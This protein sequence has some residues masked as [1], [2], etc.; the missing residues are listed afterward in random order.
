MFRV[1]S[2]GEFNTPA[3]DYIKPVIC[4]KDNLAAA[5]RL[6]GMA[7]I[8]K[9]GFESILKDIQASS[10]VYLDPPYRP[11][12]LTANFTAYSKSVFADRQQQELAL[13]FSKLDK[14]G[15][16]V[17]LSNSDS[18]DFFFD[19][20]YHSFNI[21]RVPAKRLINS[22]AGKRGPVHEIVVTNYTV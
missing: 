21:V 13:V 19:R 12:S 1:N 11:L 6:L 16:A 15:V 20:L 10:F 14:M 18:Q 7:T 8:K 17:M 22:D 3:G 2:K 4:D 5:S 9:A